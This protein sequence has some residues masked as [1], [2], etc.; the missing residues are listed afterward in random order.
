MNKIIW[1]RVMT[2]MQTN[3]IIRPAVAADYGDEQMNPDSR[4]GRF[5]APIADLSAPGGG[6]PTQ[7]NL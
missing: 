6:F 7:D 3:N 2:I 4:R 5:I 1:T